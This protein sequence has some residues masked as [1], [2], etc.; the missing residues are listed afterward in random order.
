MCVCV[1]ACVCADAIICGCNTCPQMDIT[2]LHACMCIHARYNTAYM[3]IQKNLTSISLKQIVQRVI[4]SPHRRTY[5]F[6]QLWQHDWMCI[7][8]MHAP[9]RRTLSAFWM[10]PIPYRRTYHYTFSQRTHTA[11]WPLRL[12]RLSKLLA[13]IRQDDMPSPE[14]NL[15]SHFFFSSL[16][17]C[18]SSGTF[19][20]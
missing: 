14:G 17:A 3:T 13:Q 5:L 20:R 6:T 19:L 2:I 15:S 8:C 18:G 16:H 12:A 10:K 7:I 4:A 11:V 1:C 9:V